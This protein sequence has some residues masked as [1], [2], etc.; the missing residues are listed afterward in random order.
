MSSPIIYL[1]YLYAISQIIIAIYLMIPLLSLMLYSIMKLFSK[2]PFERFKKIINKNHEFGI[3]ITAHQE[4][5]FIDPLVDSILK[6]QYKNFYI[7]IVIDDCQTIIPTYENPRIVILSPTPALHSKIK[8]ID[9]AINNLKNTL[10]AIIIFDADNIIHPSF[11]DYINQY[12]QKGFEVV[13]ANFK[14]KNIDSDYARMDAIGDM[15]NF[16]IERQSRMWLGLSSA[17]WGSGIAIKLS[18]YKEIK[19]KY[20]LGGFD[21]KMQSHLVKRVNKIAFAEEAIL[22]DEKITT[23]QSLQNQRTRWI[24]SYFK[25]FKESF[26]IFQY[27]IQKINFNLIY[28]GFV[29]MRPPLFI[30]FTLA[31]LFGILNIF[32]FPGI[33]LAW[34]IIVLTFIV[35]FITIIIIKGRDV[36][37]ILTIFKLPLFIFQQ[38]LSLLK[39]KKAKKRF[40]KTEHTKIVYIKD[41]LK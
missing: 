27:G 20:Y 21:K 8:S 34:P 11:L 6:Q 37:Y 5:K 4:I 1:R 41:I 26:S 7:Y 12:F 9:Y 17:I 10:D 31:L 36:R 3:I 18:L 14:P 30:V 29:T 24:S 22:F 2:P 13:Q 25:Y 35:T 19:Y 23:G 38:F 40:L 16:F 15:F 33:V 39:I 28:F 32:I